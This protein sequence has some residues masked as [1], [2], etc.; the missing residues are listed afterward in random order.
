MVRPLFLIWLMALL[1][2]TACEHRP[3]VTAGYYHW[4]GAYAPDSLEIAALCLAPVLYLRFFDVHAPAGQGPQPVG[5]LQAYRPTPCVQQVV[6]VVYITQA[7]FRGMRP[8][9]ADMLADQLAGKL[10]GMARRWGI[11]LRQ[12]QLDC[13]WTASTR[14][15][16]FRLLR[17][18]RQQ[19]GCSQTRD[20]L[21]QGIPPADRVL[22]M[23][24]NLEDVRQRHPRNS[25]LHLPTLEGYLP[26]IRDYPLPMDV[27]LPVFG[28]AAHYRKDRLLGLVP[29][30]DS[31]QLPD[32]L[33]APLEAHTFRMV[34]SGYFAGRY[35][36]AGDVV[37]LEFPERAQVLLAAD[38]LRAHLPPH[39][40]SLSVLL[41]HLHTPNLLRYA[42]MDAF[43]AAFR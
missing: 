31:R 37:K 26:A 36:Y 34:K 28:W 10:R 43:Y 19:L 29:D 38:W 41:Y 11:P 40:D 12:V 25:I 6:P 4:K 14:G 17:R 22:L 23:A 9:E 18:V 27:A 35:G 13:D 30:A 7:T 2:S 21:A 33:F 42:P 20:T 3:Q 1:A 8:E 15:L 5:V 16:Y 32:S 24:Y 39:T